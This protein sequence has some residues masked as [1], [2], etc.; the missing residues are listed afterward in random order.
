MIGVPAAL[1]G[2]LLLVVGARWWLDHFLRSDDFRKF[3]ERKT[4]AALQAEAHLEPLRW[5][6]AEVY[7][8]G[9][10]VRASRHGPLTAFNAV[11]VRAAFVLGALWRR[12]WRVETVEV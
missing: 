3:L 11:Q 6:G 1:V 5:D 9:L 2:L 12:V 4:S 10:D 7:T 8:A